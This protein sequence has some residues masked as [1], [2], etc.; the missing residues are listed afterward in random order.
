VLRRPT[1]PAAAV[2]ARRAAAPAARAVL[3]HTSGTAIVD[4][5][6]SDD[7]LRVSLRVAV[8]CLPVNIG[9]IAAEVTVLER[10]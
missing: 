3:L 8:A 1:G 2:G 5:V 10:R 6:E 9:G 7:D 4:A